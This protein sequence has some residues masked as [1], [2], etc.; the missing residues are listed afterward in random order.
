MKS[1]KWIF[2]LFGIL[3]FCFLFF[4]K[5]T[6]IT[7]IIDNAFNYDV[8]I[9]L[10]T[11]VINN[12]YFNIFDD[13]THETET[14]MGINNAIKYAKNNNIQYI[15]L[16][17]GIYL[18]DGS[19]DFYSENEGI[20]LESNITLDLNESKIIHKETN[21]EH[22]S[23]LTIF[24]K[25][26]VNIR[27]GIL[28]GVGKNDIT[29]EKQWGFGVDIR[30]SENI[31]IENLEIYEMNGDGIY[32]SNFNNGNS[33]NIQ[34]DNN[35]IHDCNRQGITIIEG[36]EIMISNNEIFNIRRIESTIRNRFG[37]KL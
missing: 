4:N 33:I 36:N 27:N 23:L 5:R 6:I 30:N 26:N 35:V 14:T 20:I 19:G 15:A 11:G 16:E 7:Q 28:V 21:S 2:M 13:G 9:N 8:P 31:T 37:G 1:K 34:I 32:I 18:V 12:K 17:K 24:N 10:N 3:I 25:E 29:Q 22:Y